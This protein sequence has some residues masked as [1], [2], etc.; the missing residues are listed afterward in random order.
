MK[1]RLGRMPEKRVRKLAPVCKEPVS[2]LCPLA[3]AQRVLSMY[4]EDVEWMVDDW[5]RDAS[6]IRTRPNEPWR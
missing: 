6:D 4:D 1:R 3:A 5:L 2:E